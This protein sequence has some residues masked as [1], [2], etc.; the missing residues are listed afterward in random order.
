[1]PNCYNDTVFRSNKK[2]CEIQMGLYMVETEHLKRR[3]VAFSVLS[4]EDTD[5]CFLNESG[6]HRMCTP[7][8]DQPNKTYAL[9]F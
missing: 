4:K 8:K 1:M 6:W 3:G 9:I 2:N 5:V 7:E